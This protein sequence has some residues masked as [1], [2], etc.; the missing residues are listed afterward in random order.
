MKKLFLF[1]MLIAPYVSG[2]AQSDNM[3]LQNLL[4]KDI[5]EFRSSIALSDDYG[6]IKVYNTKTGALQ[7]STLSE[8]KIIANRNVIEAVC[9]Y[10]KNDD[11]F[12]ASLCSIYG[13]PDRFN[14]SYCYWTGDDFYLVVCNDESSAMYVK[15]RTDDTDMSAGELRFPNNLRQSGGGAASSGGRLDTYV[16]SFSKSMGNSGATSSTRNEK[17]KLPSKSADS[18]PNSAKSASAIARRTLAESKT[19]VESKNKILLKNLDSDRSLMNYKLGE[20]PMKYRT[21]KLYE[22]KGLEKTYLYKKSNIEAIVLYTIGEQI[23]SIYYFSENPE[24]LNLLLGTFTANYGDPGRDGNMYVWDGQ[25]TT[26]VID[27]TENPGYVSIHAKNN[28]LV[29]S[30]NR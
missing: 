18:Q 8:I 30:A 7:K 2:R 10:S 6:D 21:L 29:T 22:D 9:V 16:D 12:Y 25:T 17:V 13:K 15:T 14:S 24:H 3:S 28:R 20:N 27:K 1:V 26:A 4:G 19:D 11:N 5:S 23:T